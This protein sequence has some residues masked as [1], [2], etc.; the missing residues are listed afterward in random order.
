MYC[1]NLSAVTIITFVRILC[2]RSS[3]RLWAQSV[4][5]VNERANLFEVRNCFVVSSYFVMVE[6][7]S[8]TAVVPLN[9]SN[10]PTWKIQCKMALMKDG[11]WKIV[12]GE[13]APTGGA[14]ELAKF[15][16][17]RDRALATIV[18]S[19]DT[20]LLYIISD[21]QDP[22]AVWTKLGNQFEK[23]TWGT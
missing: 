5:S 15:A 7:K 8:V 13:V 1:N 22:V 11:L 17:R 20:S 14:S 3:N 16:T 10:Y 2:Q 21:P 6:S 19:V 12:I 9:C 4:S 18:L 23:K